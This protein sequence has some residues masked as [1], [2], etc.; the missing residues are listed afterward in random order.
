MQD[1]HGA[2]R[3]GAV[4]LRRSDLPIRCTRNEVEKSELVDLPLILVDQTNAARTA[5]DEAFVDAGLSAPEATRLNSSYAAQAH[6]ASGRGAAVVTNAATFGLCPVPIMVKGRQ[7]RVRLV[8]AWEP[9]HY[10]S[11]V[12]AQ[13]LDD[14]AL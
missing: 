1:P 13:W 7:V 5:F 14:L 4:L 12:I 11:S 2:L 8:A 9:G 10:A 3:T 6:A